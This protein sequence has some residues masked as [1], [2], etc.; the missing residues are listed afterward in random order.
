MQ[1]TQVSM[2]ENTVKTGEDIFCEAEQRATE[3]AEA[4][5]DLFLNHAPKPRQPN[6]AHTIDLLPMAH[7]KWR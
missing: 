5:L 3:L 2:G 1:V 4:E 7:S 6:I